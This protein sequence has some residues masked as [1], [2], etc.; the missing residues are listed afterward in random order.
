MN[1]LSLILG[2]AVTILSLFTGLA[3]MV[4]WYSSKVKKSYA[5]ERDFN[6]LK[7]SHAQMVANIE[8]LWRQN[9]DRFDAV[10]RALDRIAA[11]IDINGKAIVAHRLGKPEDK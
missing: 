5:A 7:N 8:Q 6:H 11:Q 2:I 9:D 4:A 1:D 10:D 3:G